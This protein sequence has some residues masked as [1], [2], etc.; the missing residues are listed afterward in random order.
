MISPPM[1]KIAIVILFFYFLLDFSSFPLCIIPQLFRFGET[2]L[3]NFLFPAVFCDF[4]TQNPLPRGFGKFGH[5]NS[6]MLFS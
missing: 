2:D 5:R 1:K 6:T 3:K 4:I